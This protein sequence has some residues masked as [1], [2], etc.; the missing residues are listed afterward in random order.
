LMVMKLIKKQLSIKDLSTLHKL[1]Y[2]R[3]SSNLLNLQSKVKKYRLMK[4]RKM[5][6]NR[7]NF[8]QI[9]HMP[10]LSTMFCASQFKDKDKDKDSNSSYGQLSEHSLDKY[11]ELS[12]NIAGDPKN[13]SSTGLA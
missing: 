10:K 8:H 11:A 5:S 3:K 7:A 4:G 12:K 9:K 13:M 1:Y 2:Y 6:D